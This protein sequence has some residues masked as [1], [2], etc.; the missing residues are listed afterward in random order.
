MTEAQRALFGAEHGPK[1]APQ[2]PDSGAQESPRQADSVA[3]P[4]ASVDLRA[5]AVGDYRSQSEGVLL[6][7]LR[8]GQ[9]TLVR[10]RGELLAMPGAGSNTPKEANYVEGL[11]LWIAL[12]MELRERFKLEG[13]VIEEGHCEPGAVVKCMFCVVKDGP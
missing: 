10:V 13:C 1:P 2:A 5:A 4:P 7:R 8:Q 12:E 9:R 6:A 3:Q 11:N